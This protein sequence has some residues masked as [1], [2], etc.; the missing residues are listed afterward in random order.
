VKPRV[1]TPVPQKKKKRKKEK[2][3]HN[4]LFNAIFQTNKW[5]LVC[6]N[7]GVNFW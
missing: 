6:N 2:E 4:V 1:Q 5:Y 3:K 7:R